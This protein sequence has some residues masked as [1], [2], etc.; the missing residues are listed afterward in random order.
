MLLSLPI[1][2]LAPGS[3]YLSRALQTVQ[4]IGFIFFLLEAHRYAYAHAR[5][6]MPISFNRNCTTGLW[7]LSSKRQ[8]PCQVAGTLTRAC[9]FAGYPDIQPG[10]P[11]AGNQC[12]CKDVLF[13]L[14]SACNYCAESETLV[15]WG[16]WNTA[17]NCSKKQETGTGSVNIS[18]TSTSVAIPSWANPT[19]PFKTSDL[20]NSTLAQSQADQTLVQSQS[21]TSSSTVTEPTPTQTNPMNNHPQAPPHSSRH[22][23]AIL[24]G[25]FGGLGALAILTLIFILRQRWLKKE[26]PH[27]VFEDPGSRRINPFQVPP[28][29]DEE[30]WELSISPTTFRRAFQTP[31][32]GRS[33]TPGQGM[34]LEVPNSTEGA[35][36]ER[37][38][39]SS[40]Q[41][42]IERRVV[43]FE[44]NGTS[45][46]ALN[47]EVSLPPSPTV[48]DSMETTTHFR[49]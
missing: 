28:L 43:P 39:P 48:S 37:S 7:T 49:H 4:L 27:S 8:S 26:R 38:D 41:S 10:Y 33:P 18:T 32:F 30:R 17:N 34:E 11:T 25:V 42:D 47:R 46:N 45:A 12:L 1:K 22:L 5:E 9:D 44:L 15:S 14:L 6:D 2:M 23:G 3:R 19:S 35:L 16:Q 36:S 24:G 13:S 31:T 21:S 29:T 40:Y 20:C